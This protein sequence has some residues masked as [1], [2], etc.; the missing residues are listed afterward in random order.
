MSNN[1]LILS[2]RNYLRFPVNEDFYPTN[3]ICIDFDLTLR[4]WNQPNSSQIVGNFDNQG[5]G[6]FYQNGLEEISNLTITDCG[7]NHLSFFNQEGKLL[8]QRDFPDQENPIEISTQTIDHFGNKYYYDQGNNKVFR[9]DTNNILVKEFTLVGELFEIITINIDS[10]GDVYFLNLAEDH[11]LKYTNAGSYVSTIALSQSGHTN[12]VITSQDEIKSFYSNKGTPMLTDCEDNHYN[13]FG[14]TIYKN[15]NGFF[16]ASIKTDTFGIDVNDDIWIVYQGNK[17]IKM[18]KRGRVIFNKEFHNIKPC[19]TD[20]CDNTKKGVSISF[21][22][23]LTI[24]GYEEYTW[25]VL[26]E[27]NYA[28]KLNGNADII[29]CILLTNLLDVERYPETSFENVRF[30]ANG[31]F[32]SFRHKKTYS[33]NCANN[34]DSRI[35][36]RVAIVDACDGNVKYRTLSHDVTSLTG[37]HNFKFLY[38]GLDGQGKLFLN[39]NVVDSFEQSGVIFYDDE[40]SRPTLIGADSGNFRAKKEELGIEDPV[41]FKGVIDNLALSKSFNTFSQKKRILGPIKMEL[42]TKYPVSFKED[43]DLFYMFRPTGFKS[44]RFNV[45]LI[46]SGF[47]DPEDQLKISEEVFDVVEQNVPVTNIIN[48]LNWKSDLKIKDLREYSS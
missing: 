20:P 27:S 10:V 5:Y 38:N 22:R 18:D 24:D 39:G 9:F 6:V 44:S 33:V 34:N 4:S 40:N 45:N 2:G 47:E 30:C 29:D 11:I 23:K 8:S 37:T 36:A 12:F 31:D 7:N 32:T 43:I 46:N 15:G 25:V 28:L 3:T 17:L 14:N 21:T 1:T 16:F 26:E 19:I 48:K 42:P 13:L 41:F 35:V